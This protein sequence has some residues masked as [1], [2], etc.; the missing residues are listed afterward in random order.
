MRTGVIGTKKPTLSYNWDK[1]QQLEFACE[2][3]TC[4]NW[5]QTASSRG[6]RLELTAAHNNGVFWW[7]NTGT[8]W[9]QSAHLGSSSDTAVQTGDVSFDN[10][11]RKASSGL[12]RL[13]TAL[14]YRNVVYDKLPSN[15]VNRSQHLY[16]TGMDT[17]CWHVFCVLLS[18]SMRFKRS[19][20]AMWEDKLHVCMCVF[21]TCLLFLVCTRFCVFV[22]PWCSSIWVYVV[23]GLIS[24]VVKSRCHPSLSSILTVE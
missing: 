9:R 15:D 2:W 23:L 21:V 5:S 12:T 14:T 4:V 3:A 18:S 16:Q 22:P 24:K 6:F 19:F 10:H 13:Q 11:C 1:Q 7:Q 8:T 17:A 20:C